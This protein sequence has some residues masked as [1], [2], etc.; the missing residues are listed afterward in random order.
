MSPKEVIEKAYGNIPKEVGLI[1]FNVW[2]PSYTM[3]RILVRIRKF[4]RKF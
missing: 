1:S 4:F 2:V 3:K